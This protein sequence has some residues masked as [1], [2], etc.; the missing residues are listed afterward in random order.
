MCPDAQPDSAGSALGV[1]DRAL[2]V[3]AVEADVGGQGLL[4]L[5]PGVQQPLSPAQGERRTGKQALVPAQT[6]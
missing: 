4:R 5:S 3:A 2:K 1:S 6:L